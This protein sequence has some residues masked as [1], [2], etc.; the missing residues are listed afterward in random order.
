[1]AA[2]SFDGHQLRSGPD[3]V[4]D[5]TLGLYEWKGDVWGVMSGAGIRRGYVT[6]I[7][8]GDEVRLAVAAL[9]DDGRSHAFEAHGQ[10]IEHEGQV[11]L[12]MDWE[13][14]PGRLVSV[15][16]ISPDGAP[17]P[18]TDQRPGPTGIVH[19]VEVDE[20]NLREILAVRPAPHQT[21]YVADNACSIA[22]AHLCDPPGW[23]RAVYDEDVCVGFVMLARFDDPA[24]ELYARYHGWYLW[25]LLVGARH[26]RRGYGTQ[27]MQLVCEH[28][29]AEGGPRRLTTSWH[30]EVGG[31]EPFYRKLGF[32]PTGEIDDGEVVAVLMRWP[33]PIPAGPGS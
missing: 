29:D 19:L 26:Q 21:D 11:A 16:W 2:P 25:R 1:V 33:D 23:Y 15:G 4:D 12:D 20:D 22:E 14:A 28:I 24:H 13:L 27:V 3:A 5:L 7:R 30:D 17:P 18:P 8:E 6:G 10:V 9:D 31:P 32:E